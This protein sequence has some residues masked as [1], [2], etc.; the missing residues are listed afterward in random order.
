MFWQRRRDRAARVGQWK[1][2]EMGSKQ[3][4]YDLAA[5]PGEEHDLS[6]ENPAMLQRVKARWEEWRRE[7]DAAEPR[8]PF[9]DY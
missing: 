1:W 5:D 3:G 2:L 6:S 7:M 4:L 9:R 8:G